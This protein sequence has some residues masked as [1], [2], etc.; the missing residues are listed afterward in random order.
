MIAA[1]AGRRID[2]PNATA[3]RFPPDRIDFVEAA[4]RRQLTADGVR[5]LVCAAACGAD[6]IA[7]SVASSLGLRRCVVLPFA[8]DVFRASSVIDRRGPYPWGALYDRLIDEAQ[9]AGDLQILG[10]EPSD[11]GAFEKTN[12]AILD[13]ALGLRAGSDENVE[14]IVVRE[15]ESRAGRDYTEHFVNEAVRRGLPVKSIP[16]D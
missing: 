3:G 6:L 5:V 2:P 12:A 11:V 8:V 15:K 14:A 16:I 4:I 1:F 7:L 10:F 13:A 9:A